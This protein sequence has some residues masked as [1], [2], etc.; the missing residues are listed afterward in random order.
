MAEEETQSAAPLTYAQ[1]QKKSYEGRAQAVQTNFT[2]DNHKGLGFVSSAYEGYVQST[3]I[4]TGLRYGLDR[5]RF[6]DPDEVRADPDFNVY[7]HYLDNKDTHSDMEVFVKNGYFDTVYSEAQYDRRR[8]VIQDQIKKKEQLSNANTLGVLLGGIASIADISTLIPGYNVIKKVK[9]AGTLGRVITSKPGQYGIMGA[10]QSVVQE[11]GLHVLNDLQT[12]EESAINTLFTAALGGGI[13][14]FVSARNPAST[15]NPNNP[16]FL[17]NENNR[18]RAGFRQFGESMSE[19]S[20]YQ[21]AKGKVGGS[22]EA[23]LDTS[24]GQSLSAAATSGKRSALAVGGKV[25]GP[26]RGGVSLFGKAGLKITKN[27]VGRATPILRMANA[28]SDKV[29]GI[30]RALF[31][32]GGIMSENNAAGFA[33]TSVESLAKMVQQRYMIT[34]EVPLG[35]AFR[36]LQL[37]VAA[38]TNKGKVGMAVDK[39]K[40]GLGAAVDLAK[41]VGRGPNASGLK[42]TTPTETG[43]ITMP[44][45]TYLTGRFA[46]GDVDDALLKEYVELFGQEATDIIAA[47]AK[48]QASALM[49]FNDD[50]A[51]E[52]IEK[53]MMSPEDKVDFYVAPQKWIGKRITANRAE[54]KDFFMRLFMDD[55]EEQFLIDSYGITKEQF[56]A[57]GKTDVVLK[58]TDAK[59]EEVVE[60]ITAD[61]G[62][63]YRLELL[64]DWSAELGLD[65]ERTLLL[66]F[67]HAES[68]FEAAEKEAI[69]AASELRTNNTQIKNAS[70]DEGV[71]LVKEQAAKIAKKKKL[72]KTQRTKKKRAEAEL[73]KLKEEIKLR[74]IEMKKAVKAGDNPMVVKAEADVMEAEALLDLFEKAGVKN[75]KK[76]VEAARLGLTQADEVL[77]SLK[78]KSSSDAVEA[79]KAKLVK[80]PLKNKRTSYLEGK[81]SE[82]NKS[83][84]SSE[85]AIAKMEMELG[86]I[87]TKVEIAVRKRQTLEMTRK[88]RN[89]GVKNAQKGARKAKRNLK[90]MKRLVKK[91][92]NEKPLDNYVDDLLDTLAKR[93]SGNTPLSRM[94][95][96]IGES[97]R[98]KERMINLTSEQRLEAQK[99]GILSDDVLGDTRQAMADVSVRMAMRDQFSQYGNSVDDIKKNMLRDVSKDYEGLIKRAKKAGDEKAARKLTKEQRSREEDISLSIDRIM[100]RLDMPTNPE[101][102]MSFILNKA[103]EW[104][105]IRYMSGALVPSTT[106]VAN[107]ALA[108]GFGTLSRR[109]LGQSSRTML[110]MGNPEIRRLVYAM[111]LMNHNN[112]SMS[113]TGSDD[114]RLQSGVG[115]FGSWRHYYTSTIDRVARELADATTVASGMRF[116]N[117]RLKLMAMVEQQ[118]N[119][120]RIIDNYDELLLGL[121]RSLQKGASAKDLEAARDISNLASTGIGQDQIRRMKKLM[122]NNKPKVNEYGVL[123]LDFGKWKDMG[124]EGQLAHNDILMALEMSANRAV[125]TPGKGDTPFFMS[126][127]YARTFMQFQTY[128]FV[129]MTKYMVPAFQRMA[130]YGDLQAFGTFGLALATGSTVV[131][132]KDILRNGEIKERTM[133][134]W[135]YE[136]ID[137]SGFLTFLSVPIEGTRAAFGMD[138]GSRYQNVSG[139]LSFIA[140]PTGGLLND[141]LDLTS[142]EDNEKRLQVANKLTPFKI[143]QQIFEVITGG[144]D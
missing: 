107:T 3:W 85:Q 35:D 20:V 38:L 52:L 141:L 92:T 13:G 136:T 111:E 54:A 125:M 45:F 108:T 75:S 91:K 122:G 105:Y 88:L 67:E 34:V 58:R 46:Y 114:L 25:A 117:S 17:F 56:T 37:A 62:V 14:V 30:S 7:G 53:G 98:L 127:E 79:K 5:G 61:E 29:K 36:E 4:G 119:I 1:I 63:E 16:D 116:W 142:A 115:D 33:D 39:T 128:G 112:R 94:A 83:L 47:S 66:A 126:G 10:Q 49:K 97:S 51:D 93:D 23:V 22:I 70:V 64:E 65:M 31:D 6:Y 41:D 120:I 71:K 28:T 131:A 104:N 72:Q 135:S 140:G 121:E 32:H 26:L 24:Y 40:R 100:G 68:A 110:G 95:D 106:D 9:V 132:A 82:I 96:E 144:D 42:G 2:S 101:S 57:L 59:G 77:R 73:A 11:T 103:R 78:T 76:D 69:R 21:G 12:V 55:P 8:A 15:L 123:E 27:T 74:N 139:R 80:K 50:F 134:E 19:S 124:K 118:H 138:G 84:K 102:M 113:F 18:I 81:L 87:S 60:T 89:Q 143:Y 109:N 99:L 86:P 44:E 137:R 130:N 90:K 43:T 48:K 133:G 129:I